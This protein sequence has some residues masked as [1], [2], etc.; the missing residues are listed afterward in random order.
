MVD[1]VGADPFGVAG[2]KSLSGCISAN[3]SASRFDFDVIQSAPIKGAIGINRIRASAYLSE[4][5]SMRTA[6]LQYAVAA[7]KANFGVT[8]TPLPTTARLV[9]HKLTDECLDRPV[10]LAGASCVSTCDR[11]LP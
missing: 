2:I 5:G 3:V 11:I 1:T 8:S 10:A 9:R 4:P 7:C 6:M